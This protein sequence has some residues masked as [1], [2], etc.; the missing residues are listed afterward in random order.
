M[1]AKL[2]PKKLN[3]KIKV[4]QK[5]VSEPK[6]EDSLNLHVMAPRFVVH[7]ENKVDIT[8][9]FQLSKVYMFNRKSMHI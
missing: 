8:I 6:E 7:W 3:Y 5:K 4:L 1:S 2:F 9:H